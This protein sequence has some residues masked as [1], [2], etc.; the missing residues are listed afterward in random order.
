LLVT[1]SA[2]AAATRIALLTQERQTGAGPVGV[3]A[4][5][6]G[7]EALLAVMPFRGKQGKLAS[8]LMS[9]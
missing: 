7:Q 3:V 6:A 1:L 8:Q 5:G 9:L 2:K 4:R